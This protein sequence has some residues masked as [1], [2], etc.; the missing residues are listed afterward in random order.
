MGHRCRTMRRRR[1]GCVMVF[2]LFSPPD[3]FRAHVTDIRLVA[4]F[5]RHSKTAA[6]RAE[7]RRPRYPSQSNL[8]P[9]I[10]GAQSPAIAGCAE[11]RPAQ[12]RRRETC[13][14]SGRRHGLYRCDSFSFKE[15]MS[16]GQVPCLTKLRR[17]LEDFS[18]DMIL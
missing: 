17:F 6:Y 10:R 1:T 16:A 8:R 9:L 7:R 18:Y 14:Y 2:F 13:R 15:R 3:I 4:R 11:T 5:Q 12:R